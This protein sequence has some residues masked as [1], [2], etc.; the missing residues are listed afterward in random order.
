MSEY[1]ETWKQIADVAKRSERWCRYTA[2]R[3]HD[4]L[5]VYKIGGIVRMERAD[6][7]RWL[8]RERERTMA[9]ARPKRPEL[10]LIV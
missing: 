7:E 5:P 4:P 8:E 3:D 9:R 10:T 1:V 6:Y 2:V